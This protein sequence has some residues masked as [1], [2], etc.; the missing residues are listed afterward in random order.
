MAQPKTQVLS[1]HDLHGWDH[2]D[3]GA[4]LRAFLTTCPRLTGPEW[5][6]ACDQAR[7]A[8]DD[9][10]RFFEAY[11]RPVLI[12]NPKKALFTGYYEPELKASLVRTP[13]FAYPIYRRPPGLKPGR[14]WY[15][16]A[17]I[18][19]RHLLRGRGL[20]I[21]W[22]SNPV[23]VF[24]LQVQGS[25][26]LHLTNGKILRV[27]F[28]GKNG[29]PYRSVGKE[30][31][32]LGLLPAHRVSAQRIR[33]WVKEHPKQ[34]RRILMHNPSFVF[35]REVSVAHGD[36]PV[37]AM[38][39]PLQAG[40]SLAVDPRYVPLGAP[41]WVYKRGRHPIHRLMVA[42]DTGSAI[43][44]AQRGDIFYGSGPRAGRLAGAVRDGGRMVV[45]LP[46]A[47]ALAMAGGE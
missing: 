12:G 28:G 15:S 31:V 38:Q 39:E 6:E 47:R 3:Q 41:V 25:G 7:H 1:F 14:R 42:Q 19:D 44:G 13:H 37:G 32:R 2:D 40:R 11:F 46:A 29:H 9:P 30:L 26:R 5:Q 43:R 8:Q 23:D 20:E 34:G 36:G 18:E 22:L 21:A 17:E 10:R 27:G 24:F 33:A 35:F 45:L 4:A 16:R